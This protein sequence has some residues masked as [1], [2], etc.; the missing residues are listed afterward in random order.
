MS[1]RQEQIEQLAK[2]LGCRLEQR[3]DLRGMMFVEYGYVEGPIIKSQIDYL[4]M[5]HELGHFGLGPKAA[6]AKR[7]RSTTSITVC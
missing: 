7:T 4:T 1:S 3:P 2:D 5:L 6:L